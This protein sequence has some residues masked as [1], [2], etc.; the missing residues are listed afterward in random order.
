MWIKKLS[1]CLLLA[2]F[3][4]C[5]SPAYSQETITYV[6][7]LNEQASNWQTLDDLLTQLESESQNL[8]DSSKI[9]EAKLAKA[10]QDLRT[11]YGWLEMSQATQTE[12]AHSLEQSEQSLIALNLSLSEATRQGATLRREAN[13]WK[14]A[15]IIVGAIGVGASVYFAT[16]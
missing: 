15:T 3:A 9:L 10:L 8:S 14:L 4:S 13:A 11:A 1:L 2:C 5:L 12:L 6:N 7:N 16:H